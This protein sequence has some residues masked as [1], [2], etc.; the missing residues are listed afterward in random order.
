MRGIA[1]DLDKAFNPKRNGVQKAVEQNIVKPVEQNVVNPIK[2]NYENMLIN[3]AKKALTEKNVI[4]GLKVAGHYGIPALTSGLGGLAGGVLG[5]LATGGAGGEFAGGVAGSALGAYGG[6]QI[7]K[8]IGID[9]ATGTG[10][11]KGSREMKEKMARI[12]AMKRK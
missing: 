4:N 12:R 7:N 1:N 10:L 5:G 9:N 2:Q 11:K 6:Q 3:P 8:A